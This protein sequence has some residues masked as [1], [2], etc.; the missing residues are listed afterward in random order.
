M[1]AK[2][3]VLK[4]FV[5]SRPT[6]PDGDLAMT[7]GMTFDPV[8]DGFQGT[9]AEF[10]A[11]VADRFIAEMYEGPMTKY[12]ITG[13]IESLTEDGEPS[14]VFLEVGSIHELP[15][16]ALDEEVE[17]GNAEV[18]TED[19]VQSGGAPETEV[20]T[21]NAPAPEN[22]ISAETP[23]MYM[24]KAIITHYMRTVGDKEYH[25]VRLE[26]GSEHDLTDEDYKA[27]TEA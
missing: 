21:E 3:T 7:E 26:D 17:A 2:Y 16:G 5:L 11:L 18:V 4:E 20:E 24:G 1:N 10:E 14:G 23:K 9:V 27:V 25:H 19:T 22:V 6:H 15:A 8:A 13:P 12:K